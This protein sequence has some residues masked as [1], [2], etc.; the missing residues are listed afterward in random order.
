MEVNG[1]L[2]VPAALLSG[3]ETR[4]PLDKR[5]GGPLSRAGR[6]GG[7]KKPAL[8]GNQILVFSFVA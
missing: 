4:C 1:N 7:E 5:L 8:V 2:H 3:K 6:F